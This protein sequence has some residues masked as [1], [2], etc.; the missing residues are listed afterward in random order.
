MGANTIRVYTILKPE[1][2]EALV[3]YNRKHESKPLYFIQGIW[4]PEEAFNKEKDALTPDVRQDFKDEI[5]HAVQA[6]Y[7]T[8]T[9]PAK[10]GKASGKYTANAGPYLAG[11]IVGT[12]W[13]P[14]L[15]KNTNDRHKGM[16]PYKGEYVQS[17]PEAEPFE[18]MLA[19]MLDTL[20][21]LETKQG[22]QHPW[23]FADWVTTD[24][25]SH[26]GEPLIQE[27]LVSV[28]PMHLTAK[29]GSAG[30]YAS[31]HVYPYYPDF[32]RKDASLQTVKKSKGRSGF[33]PGVF[34]AV[35]A[36]P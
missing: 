26:P 34:T 1:F 18:I 35:E 27:D 3:E 32:F 21:G 17:K 16:Q 31:Y 36:A 19:E 9:V 20:A 10:F 29:E 5:G 30:L 24:P 13:D 25:L 14:L 2:Y 15:V 7:G 28:D 33:L 11:W 12:E 8:G 4:S 22:W 6:V 23:A